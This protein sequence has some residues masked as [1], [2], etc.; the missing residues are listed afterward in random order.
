MSKKKPDDYVA[1]DPPRPI[2]T[3][4]RLKEPNNDS[5]PDAPS[6]DDEPPLPD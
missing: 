2:R 3:S 6:D 5:E 4:E 1:P